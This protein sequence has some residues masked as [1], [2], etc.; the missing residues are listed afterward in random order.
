MF[1]KIMCFAFLWLF[2]L[3][4]VSCSFFPVASEPLVAPLP[5]FPLASSWLEH[6]TVRLQWL[7]CPSENQANLS[8][9]VFVSDRLDQL[10]AVEPVSTRE[11]HLELDNLLPGAWFWKVQRIDAQHRKVSSP[12]QAFCV[13]GEGIP[14]P[15]DPTQLPPDP[16]LL[17]TRSSSDAFSLEWPG[18]LDPSHPQNPVAFHLYL[19]PSVS[20][21]SPRH[22]QPT[23]STTATSWEFSGL[24]ATPTFWMVTANTLSGGQSI[25]GNGQWTPANQPPREP[26]LRS[27]GDGESNIPV[28]QTLCWDPAFDPDGDSVHYWLFL[29]TV[30]FST[31]LVGPAEGLPQT[32]FSPGGLA[33]GKTYYWY[34]VASDGKGGANRSAIR[35]FQ[36]VAGSI[37]FPSSPFPSDGDPNV[38]CQ[39]PLTLHWQM[40]PH[41][42]FLFQVWTGPNPLELQP[43]GRWSSE[44]FET[45]E[46]LVPNQWVYWRVEAISLDAQ[47][48]RKQNSILGPVWKFYSKQREYAPPQIQL[49]SP[50]NG[51][52][53][54]AVS[55]EL[56]WQATPGIQSNSSL[57]VQPEISGF[58]L[59]LSRQG[60]EFSDPLFTTQTHW[61]LEGLDYAT[62]Y[63]W[64]VEALQ[65]D[66]QSASSTRWTFSTQA[67]LFAP[68][69]VWL[70][71]PADGASEQA[72]LLTL[73][74]QAAP[75]EPLNE[76]CRNPSLG[77][78][79]VFLAAMGQPYPM[80]PFHTEQ[81]AYA[82]GE[83]QPNTCYRWKVRAQQSDGQQA[84]SEEFCFTTLRETTPAPAPG[85]IMAHAGLDQ[86]RIRSAKLENSTVVR[87]FSDPA[88]ETEVASK[89]YGEPL[90]A[91]PQ[92]PVMQLDLELE[93][94]ETIWVSLQQVEK[95]ASTKTPCAC[96]NTPGP[97][98]LSS[99]SH[100][101]VDVVLSPLLEWSEAVGSVEYRVYLG[102]HAG[103]LPQNATTTLTQLATGVLEEATTFYWMVESVDAYGATACSTVSSFTTFA[104]LRPGTVTLYD[105]TEGTLKGVFDLLSQAI[106]AGEAGDH[107]VVQEGM[108]LREAACIV[109]D[110]T[111]FWVRSEGPE[112]FVLD[113]EQNDGPAFQL[114]NEASLTLQNV[115]IQNGHS[116]THDVVIDVHNAHLTTIDASLCNNQMGGI[117]LDN[118]SW[119]GHNTWVTRNVKKAIAEAGGGGVHVENN[120]VVWLEN[121]VISYNEA[122]SSPG[123]G[124]VYLNGVTSTLS[125]T[126]TV[127]SNNSCTNYGGGIFCCSFTGGI[128]ANNLILSGNNALCGGG[129]FVY[130]GN[131]QANEMTV[132][133]NQAAIAGAGIYRSTKYFS[134]VFQTSGNNWTNTSDQP[135]PFSV[136]SDGSLHNP[137]QPSDPVQVKENSGGISPTQ[138]EWDGLLAPAVLP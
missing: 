77:E 10:D 12:I 65:Q 102:N 128:V 90:S 108:V 5:V 91:R 136:G 64:Q 49:L 99:P 24:P 82:T 60:E 4:V 132:E 43:M 121:C 101:Q 15:L 71:S 31:Q 32:E 123:G 28:D 114:Q 103:L 8:Y 21:T 25:V 84:T 87:V 106:A 74:W 18:F 89:T 116:V 109:M 16:H 125:A 83:L 66:G 6:A 76:G 1:R 45:L 88:S 85:E 57:R 79:E 47:S 130:R 100:C 97:T 98:T 69:T 92:N 51:G 40:E 104:P 67:Q 63:H 48:L 29:D 34:V 33:E 7:P 95:E 94:G 11:C 41:E 9:R 118:G 50:G 53:D 122:Q 36:T 68:P 133:N 127:I 86:V 115:V 37:P 107:I 129:I 81:C 61:Q 3:F 119:H 23:A 39:L 134:P 75:G 112:P 111:S 38:D 124:G 46:N 17:V 44:P 80:D 93:P 20:S 62:T 78:Y 27:P 73:R 54:L 26:R 2:T 52:N 131:L 105:N 19:F 96:I 56:S 70:Q 117:H 138:M 126:N 135:T 120:S 55:L 22:I 42:S 13:K 35:S 30:P 137:S 113:L 58:H 14:R 110:D 72:T 59:F